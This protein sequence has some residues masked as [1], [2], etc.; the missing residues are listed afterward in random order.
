[1]RKV[2]VL[3]SCAGRYSRR[4]RGYLKPLYHVGASSGFL[5]AGHYI[6]V[7]SIATRVAATDEGKPWL[8]GEKE[9]ERE[10]GTNI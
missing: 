9:I 6:K 4:E 8:R 5:L 10:C 1:M 2:W 7:A 3:R